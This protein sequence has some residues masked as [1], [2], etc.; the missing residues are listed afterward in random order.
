MRQQGRQCILHLKTHRTGP[1][2]APGEGLF[3][4]GDEKIMKEGIRT[5]DW[6]VLRVS[7]QGQFI[8]GSP[9]FGADAEEGS[10]LRTS[11]VTMVRKPDAARRQT[12][13]GQL[14]QDAHQRGH[15]ELDLVRVRM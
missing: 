6:H 4:V 15:P 13:V 9:E 14:P 2:D 8:D 11:L 1:L 7:R 10:E 12:T 3:K 5:A